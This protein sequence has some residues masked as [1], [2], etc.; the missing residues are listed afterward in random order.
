MQP[1]PGSASASAQDALIKYFP[2]DANTSPIIVLLT[3]TSGQNITSYLSNFTLALQQ[4][5]YANPQFTNLLNASFFQSY[6]TYMQANLSDVANGFVSPVSD[7]CSHSI[8]NIDVNIPGTIALTT[9]DKSLVT[10]L[11][12]TVNSLVAQ[13]YPDG[14]VSVQLTGGIVFAVVVQS[15]TEHDLYVRFN[16][17][18][19]VFTYPL[20]AL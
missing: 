5:T 7:N 1:P 14:E 15:G 20:L 17:T 11:Q 3:Q 6:T 8:I 19:M 2:S 18:G 12:D 16:M 4:E 10:F 13:Y 9:E